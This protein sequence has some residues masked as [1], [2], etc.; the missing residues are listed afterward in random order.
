MQKQ[1]IPVNKCSR[2]TS[3]VNP[4]K[5]FLNCEF[6]LCLPPPFLFLWSRAGYG[7]LCSKTVPFTLLPGKNFSNKVLNAHTVFREHTYTYTWSI[8]ANSWH[9]NSQKHTKVSV[10]F[11]FIFNHIKSNLENWCMGFSESPGAL[12]KIANASRRKK[13]VLAWLVFHNNSKNDW[14][15]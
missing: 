14:F 1:I 4:F 11:K 10:W 2:I 5:K 15:P 7:R 8:L 13:S 12:Y 3:P 9:G 6:S